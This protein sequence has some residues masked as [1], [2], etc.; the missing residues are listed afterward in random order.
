MF[1]LITIFFIIMFIIVVIIVHCTFAADMHTYGSFELISEVESHELLA[2]CS[3]MDKLN[4]VILDCK[5]I[6][7]FV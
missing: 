6:L 2:I 1:A 5:C 4:H 3:L 7:I